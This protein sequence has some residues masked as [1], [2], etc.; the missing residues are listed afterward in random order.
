MIF[1]PY[2]AL[3]LKK[4]SWAYPKERNL[5]NIKCEHKMNFFSFFLNS[6][7]SVNKLPQRYNEALSP[8]EQLGCKYKHVAKFSK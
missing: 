6:K 1:V 8:S 7:R 4:I 2:Q 5:K 3:D